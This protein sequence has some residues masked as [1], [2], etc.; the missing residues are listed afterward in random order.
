MAWS[1]TGVSGRAKSK[2]GDLGDGWLE[3]RYDTI[4]YDTIRQV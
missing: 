4:R 2:A 1:R 3:R